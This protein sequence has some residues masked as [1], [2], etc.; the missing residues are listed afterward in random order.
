MLRATSYVLLAKMI[1]I[2]SDH[3]GFE[4]KSK[5]AEHLKAKG[6]EVLDCGP[7]EFVSTDDYP[8][9]VFPCAKKVAENSNNVGIVIGYSGQG[10]AVVA[11]KVKGIRAVVYYG[12]DEEIIILSRQHN[13]ANVLALGSHFVSEEMAIKAVDLWMKTPFEGG[14]HTRRV[15]KIKEMEV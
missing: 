11:N 1:Y 5:I 9:F 15:E 7:H 8:D 10:E 13:D 4:L 3:A 14:R 12:G 6:E 2:A